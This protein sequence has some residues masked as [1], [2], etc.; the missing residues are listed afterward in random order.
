MYSILILYRRRIVFQ[1]KVGKVFIIDDAVRPLGTAVS[2]GGDDVLTLVDADAGS[3]QPNEY[4]FS[5]YC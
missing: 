4:F 1:D 5:D 2:K 3:C